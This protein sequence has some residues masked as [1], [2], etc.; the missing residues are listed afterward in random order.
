[1]NFP[2]ASCHAVPLLKTVSEPLSKRHLELRD[3][4]IYARS[5]NSFMAIVTR[6]FGCRPLTQRIGGR[7][8]PSPAGSLLSFHT[9]C[10]RI[11]DIV[12]HQ[13][14]ND[15][16]HHTGANGCRSDASQT[17]ET[18]ENPAEAGKPQPFHSYPDYLPVVHNGRCGNDNAVVNIGERKGD[19]RSDFIYR[20]DDSYLLTYGRPKSSA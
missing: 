7:S 6:H 4:G 20:R 12:Q 18:I 15:P 1:M 9:P 2:S 14:W 5:S 13:Q 10:D 19:R 16:G 3:L 11:K 17:K 8:P